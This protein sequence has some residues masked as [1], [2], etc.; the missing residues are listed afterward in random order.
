MPKKYRQYTVLSEPMLKYQWREFF[1]HVV[2]TI[3]NMSAI[4]LSNLA[5]FSLQNTYAFVHRLHWI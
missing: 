2:Y 4:C 3:K 5:R 1:L